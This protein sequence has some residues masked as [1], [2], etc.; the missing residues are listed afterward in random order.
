[1]AVADRDLGHQADDLARAGFDAVLVKPF[2]FTDI[3]RL[4]AA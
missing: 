1:V 3:E 4:L 2:L